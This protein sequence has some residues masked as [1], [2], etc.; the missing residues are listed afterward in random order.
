MN[1]REARRYFGAYWD[2]EL[3]QAER[4]WLEGH[5]AACADCR[6]GYDEHARVL[7]LA[8]SLPRHEP[9]TGF[10]ERVLARARRAAPAPD[11]VPSASPAW[12][13]VTAAAAALLLVG[14][15]AVPWL[16]PRRDMPRAPVATLATPAPDAV[17]QAASAPSGPAD[18]PGAPAASGAAP[19]DLAAVP[20]SLFDHSASVEFILDPV[21][22]RRGRPQ[23]PSPALPVQAERAV[24]S[25]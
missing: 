20:D 23:A 12:L 22:L 4:E 10:T 6:R 14:T 3:T 11:R 2:D 24:I 8:A 15:L 18:A 19:T 17:P 16:L 1:C 9:E 21:P 7:E 13:P 25:F 5:F